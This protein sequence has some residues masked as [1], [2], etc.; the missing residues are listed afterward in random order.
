M[1]KFLKNIR[2]WNWEVIIGFL[3]VFCAII[4]SNHQITSSFEIFSRQ[5]KFDSTNFILQLRIDSLRFARQMKR[6][7]IQ[8][9]RQIYL[10]S[11]R[12]E[13]NQLLTIEQF[14]R[15]LDSNSIYFE[16]QMNLTREELKINRDQYQATLQLMAD[17]ASY[18]RKRNLLIGFLKDTK[19]KYDA[20]ARSFNPDQVIIDRIDS[21]TTNL[22]RSGKLGSPAAHNAMTE[23]VFQ[24]FFDYVD[25]SEFEYDST[26]LEGFDRSELFE[27][28]QGSGYSYYYITSFHKAAKSTP[29][30][31][32]LE[33]TMKLY[34]QNE[35]FDIQFNEQEDMWNKS[36]AINRES[37][38]LRNYISSFMWYYRNRAAELRIILNKEPEKYYLQLFKGR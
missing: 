10:D 30:L 36:N 32:F 25:F 35:G 37:F 26:V 20:I 23:I 33:Y 12:F 18:A 19:T 34:F 27:I 13:Q 7:S 24:K 17:T 29:N 11:I 6:D 14:Q 21:M 8:F 5:K 15:Q 1:K 16:R 31:R 2:K 3:T 22:N 9:H 28:L 4:I 38:F